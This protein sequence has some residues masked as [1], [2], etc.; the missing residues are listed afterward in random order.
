MTIEE[1]LK[2]YIILNYKSLRN[3]VNNSGVGIPY[4]TVDGILK[5]GINKSSIDN[6]IKICHALDI[7]ADYLAQGKI[8][9]NDNIEQFSIFTELPKMVE[10]MRLNI[11]E[12]SQ[13][14]I[15]DKILTDDEAELL[16]DSIEIAVNIV[17]RKRER[18]DKS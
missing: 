2:Q 8:M 13:F 10:Y 1:K 11:S 7:S 4:T 12:L 5:R 15:D 14:T 6:V 17:K 9:P 16:V 18:E 3:F